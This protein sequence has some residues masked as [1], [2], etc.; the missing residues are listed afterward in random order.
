[1]ERPI[2]KQIQGTL[3][4]IIFILV[5]APLLAISVS[6][7]TGHLKNWKDVPQIANDSGLAALG[8]ACGWI[9]LASPFA[10]SFKTYLSQAKQTSIDAS[11]TKTTSE[12]SLEVTIPVKPPT[13][14]EK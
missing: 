10:G 8:I 6:G 1:M 7:A 11:G 3:R 4:G 14:E 13:Q 9:V 5:G 12:K 2:I